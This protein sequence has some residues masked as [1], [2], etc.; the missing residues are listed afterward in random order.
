MTTDRPTL[1]Y[2]SILIA[3][4]ILMRAAM[5][6]TAMTPFELIKNVF[7]AHGRYLACTGKPLISDRIEAWKHGPVIPVL[8]HELKIYGDATIPSLRYC[9][10]PTEKSPSREKQFNDVLSVTERTIIDDV[11]CEYGSWTMPELYQLC[12]EKGS[13]WY[14]CYTG[15]R[16]V[17]IPDYTIKAYYESEMMAL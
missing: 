14:Q 2:S 3:D 5:S 12:H 17:E 11:V 7:I 1:G 15:E 6:G 9:G 13:P 10:T 16:G 4:Y 8:Y